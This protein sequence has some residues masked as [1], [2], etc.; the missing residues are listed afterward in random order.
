MGV[1]GGGEGRPGT[2]NFVYQKWHDQIFGAA[3]FILCHDGHF[4]LGEGGGGRVSLNGGGGRGGPREGDGGG[5]GGGLWGGP[6]P[7]KR[8]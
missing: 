3:N 5:G 1:G 4:G 7:P 2:L 8:P 6:P